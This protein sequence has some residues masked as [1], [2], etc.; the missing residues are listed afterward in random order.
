MNKIVK[1]IISIVVPLCAGFVGSLFTTPNIPTWYAG[2][3][4]PSFSPPNWIFGPV[5]TTLFILMGIAF[6]I[7][8]SQ[9]RTKQR[10]VAMMAYGV[11]IVL[12]VLWSVLFFGMQNPG[13]AFIEIFVLWIAIFAN[14]V[15]FYRIHK[16]AGLLLVPYILWVSFA[17]ILNGA[18]YFLNR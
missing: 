1:F 15:L 6:F 18:I 7:I 9:K 4:K 16:T 17:S 2:I 8:W 11:Q 3:Q 10:D 13:Y 12:N 14:I 5:W